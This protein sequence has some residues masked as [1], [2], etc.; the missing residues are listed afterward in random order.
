MNQFKPDGFDHT[1]KRKKLS[2]IF[3]GFTLIFAL[4]V[5]LLPLYFS[6]FSYLIK[7]VTATNEQILG[8]EEKLVNAEEQFV[9]VSKYGSE[10]SIEERKK[11][12]KKISS[13]IQ[14]GDIRELVLKG[15]METM[16]CGTGDIPPLANHTDSLVKYADENGLD[17]KITT[18]I[19]G[20][21]SWFGCVG[22]AEEFHNA[23]GYGG[24]IATRF[25][26]KTWE[27]GI[28]AFSSGLARGYGTNVHER[29]Y[30]IASFYVNGCEGEH[31][32]WAEGVMK[33]LRGIENFEKELK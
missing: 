1:E 30:D 8:T 13:E 23:W 29:L 15:Y 2:K 7:K 20:V 12:V 24:P 11:I 18:A 27:D 26:Y 4:Q 19:A 14:S 22:G 5:L 17:W 3:S 33:Y 28:S 32:P 6:L 21:E 16:R 25:R 9:D 31:N 10:V